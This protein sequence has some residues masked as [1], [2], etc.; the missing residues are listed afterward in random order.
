[1]KNIELYKELN[2]RIHEIRCINYFALINCIIIPFIKDSLI[3]GA[4]NL[5]DFENTDIYNLAHQMFC[6]LKKA[7]RIDELNNMEELYENNRH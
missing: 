7:G 5:E 1:M 3:S 2:D 4:I 6:N